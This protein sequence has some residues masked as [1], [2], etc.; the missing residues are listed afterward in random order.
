LNVI[1]TLAG[2]CAD[3]DISLQ[4]EPNAHCRF[5]S[6]QYKETSTTFYCGTAIM[7]AITP[8]PVVLLGSGETL[9]SSGKIHEF[10]AQ[11]L[12]HKPHIVILETPAGFEPNSD[13]VASKIKEF[14]TRRL[15]N[16]QPTIEVL[17]A[18]KR[19]TP[20]SPDNPDVVAPIL[21]ADEIL[22][23]PGSPTYGVRQLKDSLAFHM[24][25]ARQRRG[26]ILF[27]SSS[28]PL[29]FG[30]FTL[31]VYEIYKAGIDLHWVDGLDFFCAYGLQV[32]FISH[33][34]NN[35]GGDELDTSR[36]Y[37]GQARF[38]QLLEKL[39]ADH[40]VVGID[41]HTAII[42]DFLEG[43]CYVS[44]NDTVTILRAGET[45][46][47]QEGDRF[48][49]D[50]LGAWQ[51]PEGSAGIPGPVWEAALQA[52]VER[53]AAKQIRTEPPPEVLSLCKA[54]EAARASQDWTE[55]DSL[56][57]Q[58]AALGWLIEDTPEGSQLAPLKEEIQ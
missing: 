43:Y 55:A 7:T 1:F 25:N 45:H 39:P 14:L 36:C 24:I 29:S 47:Y 53:E 57:D 32:S 54:R 6:S 13:L 33:W 31:P 40:T 22:L 15:Q 37:I 28:A 42:M 34:N 27:L 46:V 3:R 52:E 56:R 44:G 19:G 10:A 16:Y 35:D 17:P 48:P 26:G 41:E 20:F 58:V 30:A 9:P 8:G 5:T 23:G 12:T 49:L 51:I 2:L 18:R 4:S 38:N 21:K 11:R 50:I